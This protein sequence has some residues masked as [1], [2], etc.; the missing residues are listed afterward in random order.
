MPGSHPK[1]SDLSG[2]GQD[3]DMGVLERYPSDSNMQPELQT[4]DLW[5]GAERVRR[6]LSK[7]NRNRKMVLEMPKEAFSQNRNLSTGLKITERLL[8]WRLKCF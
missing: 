1:R 4:T 5:D 2:L 7:R 8:M 6:N 3:L